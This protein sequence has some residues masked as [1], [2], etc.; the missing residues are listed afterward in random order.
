MDKRTIKLPGKFRPVFTRV[1]LLS[2]IILLIAALFLAGCQKKAESAGPVD[3]N[4]PVELVVW[5]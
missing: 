5:C 2:G 4:A 3:P 1:L